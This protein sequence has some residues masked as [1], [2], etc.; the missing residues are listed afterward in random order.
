MVSDFEKFKKEEELASA[1]PLEESPESPAEGGSTEEELVDLAEDSAG[2]AAT[3]A[4]GTAAE[5]NALE[6]D[7]A[8]Q[9]GEE[10][11]AEVKLS[12]EEIA[13]EEAAGV[14][15]K[16][17]LFCKET[18]LADSLACKYCGHVV[19]VF[20]GAVFRQLWWF[21]WAGVQRMDPS[22]ASFPFSKSIYRTELPFSN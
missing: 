10:P 17:C 13:A 15:V 22:L 21:F 5:K 8:S 18:I 1:D 20:E 9:E 7:D 3:G 16:Y 11:P 12:R 19:H 14:M 4:E 6:L 2:A